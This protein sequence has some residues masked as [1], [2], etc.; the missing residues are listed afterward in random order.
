LPF[1]CTLV[2]ISRINNALP[3]FSDRDRCLQVFRAQVGWLCSLSGACHRLGGKHLTPKVTFPP[4]TIRPAWSPC[5]KRSNGTSSLT[6]A[7]TRQPRNRKLQKRGRGEGNNTSRGDRNGGN[8]K[9]IFFCTEHGNH[10]SHPTSDCW[11]LKTRECDNSGSNKGCNGNSNNCFSNKSFCKELQRN[12][13]R[14]R[15]LI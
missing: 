9:T 13:L 3:L 11:P 4:S 8:K 6:M 1:R 5:V 14:K 12:P 10:P 7:T 2:L 15:S